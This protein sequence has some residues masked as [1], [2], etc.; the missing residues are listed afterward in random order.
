M[1]QYFYDEFWFFSGSILL[2]LLLFLA[3][4]FWFSGLAGLAGQKTSDR[5]RNFRLLAAVLFPPFA[6]FLAV[7]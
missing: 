2:A 3:F 6:I 5:A 7:I 1:L 4:I